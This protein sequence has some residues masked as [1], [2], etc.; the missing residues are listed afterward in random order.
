MFTLLLGF[1][2]MVYGL[3]LSPNTAALM[4]VVT[5][6][7][8]SVAGPVLGLFSARF[9]HLRVRVI[10]LGAGALG[11]VWGAI[12]LWPAIPPLWLLLVL[13]VAFGI[14]IP[15]GVMG[16]DHALACNP[17]E[18]LGSANGSVNGGGFLTAVILILTLGMVQ[19]GRASCRESVSIAG[20]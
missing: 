13:L 19:I 18:C 4:L 10:L 15:S 7:V 6:V 9:P 2:F 11:L 12:I 14:T 20:G 1:P 3:G 17:P 5:V 8:G 16:F